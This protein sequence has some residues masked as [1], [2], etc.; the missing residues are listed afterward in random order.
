MVVMS[1]LDVLKNWNENLEQRIERLESG[2]HAEAI[3]EPVGTPSTNILLYGDSNSS[4]KIKFGE[5]KGTLGA[6]L[7]GKSVFCPTIGTLPVPNPSTISDV[8]DVILAVGTN[9]LKED[10]CDPK[11]LAKKLHEYVKL[12]T[13]SKPA[14]RLLLPGVLPV[15]SSQGS[16]EINNKISHY[17]HYLND[18]CR[19]YQNCYYIDN[20]VFCT[21]GGS[22]KQQ[23]AKG[24]SDP[25]HLS[26]QGIKLYAS[27]FKHALRVCHNLPTGVRRGRNNPGQSSEQHVSQ[28][29]SSRGGGNRSRGRGRRGTG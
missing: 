19:V 28:N 7:P 20:R 21:P 3:W 18:L 26:D 24:E 4:G 15:H 6:A 10:S 5:G 16:S 8:S 22:L 25:L 14:T 27:R 12:M 29:T 17:N 11:N 1:L 23:F 2:A 13:K 9:D